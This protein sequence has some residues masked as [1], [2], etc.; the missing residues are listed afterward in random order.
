MWAEEQWNVSRDPK[1][2]ILFGTSNG[3]RFVF[4]MGLKHSDRFRSVLAFSVPGGGPI[5]LPEAFKTQTRSYLEAGTWERQFHEYTTRLA[6][7]L[8]QAGVPVE[9]RTRIGGHDEII[10]REEFVHRLMAVFGTR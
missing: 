6:E 10:W 4:E 2:R 5:E 3:A 7:K 1:D 8:K 9:L